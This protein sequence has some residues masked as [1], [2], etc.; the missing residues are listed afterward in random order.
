VGRK[1][2]LSTLKAE[3]LPKD[4]SRK[5]VKRRTFVMHGLGGTGKT[6]IALKFA[7][8]NREL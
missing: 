2:L 3:L 7:E 5:D 6:E 4:D 1:D 8:D